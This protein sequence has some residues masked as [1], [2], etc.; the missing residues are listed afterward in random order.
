MA[1]ASSGIHR[2]DESGVALVDP[3]APRFGQALTALFLLAGIGLV[4]PRL[5]VAVA[6]VL[7]TAVGT[8][9]RVDLWG[10]LWR[11]AAA[12]AVGR[13]AEREP[14]APHRFAKLLGAVM[15]ALA[16]GLLLAG[17]PVAGYAIAGVVALL[18]GLAAATGVCLSCRMYRGVALFRRLGVV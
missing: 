14:A 3:R 6:V 9:Y 10:A 17:V 5:V 13:T 7:V 1:T 11:H 12:R 8:G 16:S 18:A 2:W 15:T 4:E